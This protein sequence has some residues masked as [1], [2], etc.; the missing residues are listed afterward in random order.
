MMI[1]VPLARPDE[2][3]R[4]RTAVYRFSELKRTLAPPVELGGGSGRIRFATAEAA[5]EFD[6]YWR[7]FRA[8]PR[9]W[10]GFRDV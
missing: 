6:S 7:A 5:A 1:D 10:G 9:S 4:L 8:E 2:A 3:E